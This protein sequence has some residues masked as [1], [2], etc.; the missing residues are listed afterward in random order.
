M[1]QSPR[2]NLGKSNASL[3]CSDHDKH[4][5]NSTYFISP[6]FSN[7]PCLFFFLQCFF[8]QNLIAN[9]RTPMFILNAAY[10]AWQVSNSGSDLCSSAIF[11]RSFIFFIFVIPGLFVF[12]RIQVQESVAP[13]RADPRGTWTNCR[14]SMRLC[15]PSQIQHLQG[16]SNFYLMFMKQ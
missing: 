13:K 10:D 5:P 6:S 11:L 15:S 2:S 3:R 4:I 8:P 9:I 1:Y 16:G 14:K 12:T 7:F